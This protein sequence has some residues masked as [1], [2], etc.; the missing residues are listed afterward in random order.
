MSDSAPTLD[1]VVATLAAVEAFQRKL[2]PRQ[3]RFA[4][5]LPRM[6]DELAA[7][8]ARLRSITRTDESLGGTA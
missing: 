7:A 5:D 1:E 6:L 3:P 2:H 8:V 4:R